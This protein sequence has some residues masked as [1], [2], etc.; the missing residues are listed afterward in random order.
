MLSTQFIAKVS[1]SSKEEHYDKRENALRILTCFAGKIPTRAS[2]G[3]S[4]KPVAALN[5]TRAEL[6]GLEEGK[7]YLFSSTES[8]YHPE[9][10]RTVEFSCFGE[11]SPLQAVQ[12][13]AVLGVPEAISLGTAVPVEVEESIT[14]DVG[15][16]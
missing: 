3:R 10:G 9:Y 11:V 6:M 16:L 13:V 1:I 7:M 15:E 5:G 8:D 2:K 4:L 14:E 12:M